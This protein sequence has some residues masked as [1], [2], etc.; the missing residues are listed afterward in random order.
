MLLISASVFNGSDLT[1]IKVN[2]K[3]MSDY[4]CVASNGVPPDESWSVKLHVTFEPVVVPQAEI[5]QVALGGQISLVCNAEAWPR[6]LVKWEKNGK[7]IFDSPTFSLSHQASEKYHSV[8]ILTIKNVSKS[9]FG[10]YRCIAINDNG[11]HFADIVLKGE[12]F[13]ILENLIP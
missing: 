1:I 10:K 8:H 12:N 5:V 7:Q 9:D 6:P 4:I 11:E 13:Q 2:R 3:H